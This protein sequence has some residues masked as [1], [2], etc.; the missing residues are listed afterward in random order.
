MFPILTTVSTILC[1]HGG[2]LNLITS[3]TISLVDG[4]PML[5]VI[6]V[7][8]ITGCPFVVGT[9]PQPCIVARWMVGATRT[10]VNYIP[11]LL[12]N[13]VGICFSA[14]Q[15]PQGPPNIVQV[16]QKAKGI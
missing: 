10:N 4:S 6:D 5:L 12:T 13:S 1:P 9:K 3:N 16:Q 11:V 7:H 15:I 14:E 8:P 2:T